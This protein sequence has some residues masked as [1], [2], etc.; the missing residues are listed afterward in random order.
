MH[1]GRSVDIFLRLG[2]AFAFLFPAINAVFDPYSWLGYLPGVLRDLAPELVLLHVFGF[3]EV[4]I[5][6][7]IL[8]G[9][10]IFF[11]TVLACVILALIILLNLGDFQIL[12]R[13]ISILFMTLALAVL[14]RPRSSSALPS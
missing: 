8:S 13:D 14:H 11:P 4:V 7:W 9:R 3:I 1:V 10:R 5:A 2:V 6:V 12:F